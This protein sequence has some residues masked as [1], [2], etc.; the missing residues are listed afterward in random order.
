MTSPSGQASLVQPPARRKRPGLRI[1]VIVACTLLALVVVAGVVGAVI[2]NGYIADAPPMPSREALWTVRR[3]PGMTFLDRNG[4]L[5]ATRGAKYGQPVK[6]AQLPAYVPKAFLAAEDRRFYQHG[7]IDL[8]AIARAV[9]TNFRKQR[10]VEGAST[11]TQQLART[12]FLKRE[13]S[14]K[15]KVQEAYLAWELEQGMSKDEILELYLNRTYFGDGAYGLDAASQTYFGKPASQLTLTE[16]A[17]LAG[18]PNAPSRLALTNDMQGAVARG[19]HILETM[20]GEG[21]ISDADLTTALATTPVLYTAPH[22]GEGDEG[23]VLDQA[24]AEAAQLANGAAPDLVVKTTIDPALQTLGTASL[25]DVIAKQGAHRSVSQGALVTLAPDGAIL[26]MVGGLDHDKSPF[27]RVVQAHRQPGSS[28][29]AFVYGAAVERGAKPTDIRQDA[30][31]SY[32]G[33]NPENYGHGYAGAVT[34]ASALARSLNTVAVRLTLEVG[35]DSV[36]DFARRLGLTDIPP[37]PGPSIA[38]GAYEVTPLEMATG[39]QVFQNGGGRT[40]PYLVSEIHST[41]GD[42]IYA[43]ATSAPTPVLDPLYATRMVEMLKGVI[44]G[45]T[46]TSAGIGRPAAGKTGTSQD[47]RDAWFVGFTPDLLTAVWVGNDN[48]APMVKVTGGELP[49]AIWHRFMS[50][51]EKDLPSRDFPWLVAE[52]PGEP[53]LQTV[54]EEDTNGAYE[55]EP[56]DSGPGDDMGPGDRR[57]GGDAAD[58]PPP[59]EDDRAEIDSGDGRGP[60]VIHGGRYSDGSQRGYYDGA[61]DPPPPAR[62]EPDRGW[63]QQPPDYER[64]DEAPPP[65]RPTPDSSA[66]DDP[67]YRY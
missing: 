4:K 58:E 38:L 55:D 32:A 47:W 26:A 7:P 3:S 23:Y 30:P 21:W 36:A 28:F 51:A 5:I 9:E 52:P 42:L 45:G 48:G 35:P 8:H 67:R 13:Q 24:A 27:N 41:R 39:Y 34:L 60:V 49:A 10:S 16:A 11:L 18:L 6:L 40:E 31:I 2:V 56:P 20:R 12:L 19:H 44:T 50:V 54:S 15:R 17:V 63:R 64:D 61:D 59:R 37:H 33:W 25:R 62:A 22:V 53:S 1:A 65:R 46:G 43:H 29:K 57:A 14:L 66:D